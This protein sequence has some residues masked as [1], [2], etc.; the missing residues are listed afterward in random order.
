[1]SSEPRDESYVRTAFL[2]R[3]AHELRGPAG[4]TFGA[5]DQIERGV[6]GTGDPKLAAQLAMARRGVS[7]VVRTADRLQRA[8]QLERGNAPFAMVHCD[9][10]GI[11]E[12]AAHTAQVIDA[13]RGV[14]IDVT[15]SSEPCMASIDAG[16]LVSAVGEIVTNAIRFA[17]SKVRIDT[18]LEETEIRIAICDDGPGFSSPPSF[19]RFEAPAR[20]SGLGLSLPLVHE[21]LGAHGGRLEISHEEHEEHEERGER[22]GE[23]T[24]ASVILWL[25]RS[26][27]A[28]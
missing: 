10:R 3:L 2:E 24:G 8:A 21:V 19:G 14:T 1:M 9:V 5:L 22:D 4:V 25:P 13:R 11:V 16:W 6:G 17:S 12:S 26:Q 7:R 18:R 23:G 20:G 15:A 28:S 27:T